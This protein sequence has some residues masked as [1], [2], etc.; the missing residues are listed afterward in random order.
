M[1][2]NLIITIDSSGLNQDWQVNAMK[3]MIADFIKKNPILSKYEIILWAHNGPFNI[4]WLDGDPKFIEDTQK[5]DD[6]A[7]EV[8]PVLQK[9]IEIAVPSIAQNTVKHMKRV[10]KSIKKS[11]QKLNASKNK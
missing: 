7:N 8:T 5:L 4:Y 2:K 6:I 3:M 9:A 1:A 10:N 11:V